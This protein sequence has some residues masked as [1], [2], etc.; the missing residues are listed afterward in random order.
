MRNLDSIYLIPPEYSTSCIKVV[1]N[2]YHLVLKGLAYE[3]ELRKNKIKRIIT[4]EILGNIVKKKNENYCF[5]SR[6][7]IQ[8]PRNSCSALLFE[9]FL[10]M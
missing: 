9:R 8:C 6:I 1:N 4:V 2:T 5:V 10:E 3:F 7:D